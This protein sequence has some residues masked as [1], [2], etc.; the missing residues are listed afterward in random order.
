MLAA[1]SGPSAPSWRRA[2]SITDGYRE[3]SCGT[4]R[5]TNAKLVFDLAP[6]RG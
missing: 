5:L 6:R 2:C 1:R 3:H 4:T